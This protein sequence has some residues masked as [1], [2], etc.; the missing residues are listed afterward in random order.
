MKTIGV[1]GAFGFLGA[2]FVS[3]LLRRALLMPALGGRGEMGDLDIVAFSS[4]NRSNPLFDSSAVRVEVLDV[5][6][7][8]GLGRAFA[9]LDYVA[10]FAGR[11]DYRPASMREVWDIDVLGAKRVFDAA[12]A[13]GV[14]RVLY[15]SSICALGYGSSPGELADESSSPY[16]DP[17]WPISF[18]SPAEALAAIDSSLAGDY[19]FMRGMRVAYLDAKLAGW[20]LAKLYS[21]EK[22]LDVVTIFPGT[23]VGPGD[24]H[25]AITKLV[26]KVWEG[27]LPFS[28]EGES[29][30][31]DARDLAEG[32]VLALELGRSG[33][34][35]VI[36][37]REGQNLGYASFMALVAGLAREEGWLAKRRPLVLPRRALLAIAAL[38]EIIAPSGGLTRAFV[39]SGSLR[40][41]C[42]IA[43]ARSELGYEPRFGLEE[44]IVECRRFSEARGG[45]RS[46][47]LRPFLLQLQRLFP[48][49][50]GNSAR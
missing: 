10:H 34:G 17:R 15:A 45:P 46:P 36:G 8:A 33:E 40:N 16:G 24:L 9:G 50:F 12:L 23:A 32:A 14:S 30:F 21:R 37:G 1:T 25:Y 49:G 19:G 27:R 22:G 11:V 35:Y 43:K 28:F 13:A 41:S 26:N 4:K 18:S 47:R 2:N 29:S 38:A 3:A 7:S 44:G 6:D 31:V 20:E 42:S 48:F 5:L 39:L